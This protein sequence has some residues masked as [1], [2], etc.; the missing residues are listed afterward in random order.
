M[1]SEESKIAFGNN[2]RYDRRVGP[3]GNS[4]MVTLGRRTPAN[5]LAMPKS[6]YVRTRIPYEMRTAVLQAANGAV[7]DYLEK[8]D[9]QFLLRVNGELFD[10]TSP[11]EDGPMDVASFL[12]LQGNPNARQVHRRLSG[13]ADVIM[14]RDDKYATDAIADL[15][16]ATRE[17]LKE[18][19]GSVVIEEKEARAQARASRRGMSAGS[20][21]RGFSLF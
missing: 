14:A 13:G 5:V 18:I 21:S 19:A 9:S 17:R 10:P 3:M 20:A 2:L 8:I 7:R 4:I 11:P 6:E 16:A 15:S 1:T 12:L